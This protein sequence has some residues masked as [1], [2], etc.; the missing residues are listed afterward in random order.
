MNDDRNKMDQSSA[1]NEN[2]TPK[3]DAETLHTTDPQEHMQGPVSSLMQKAGEPFDT[4]ETKEE[5]DR[6]KDEKM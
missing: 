5:A 4:D 3:P 2:I 1:E 6:E